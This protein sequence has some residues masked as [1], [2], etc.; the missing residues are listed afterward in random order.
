MDMLIQC[1]LLLLGFVMLVKGADWFV[2]GAAGVADKLG[3]SQLVIG[4][5]I[6]AMGTSAPEAAV[7]ITAALKGN[8]DITI[9]NVVGSNILN[10][11]IILGIVSVIIGTPVAKS[12]IKIDLPFMLG[13]TLL[14]LVLGYFGENISR[15]EG[16]ILLLFF[17][18]YLFYLFKNAK[19]TDSPEENTK[20]EE[21]PVWKLILIALIGLVFIVLGSDFTVDAA[22]KIATELGMGTRF[23]G[24][25]IVALGTSLPELFTSVAAALKGKSDIAIGNIVGSN[26]FNILLIVGLSSVITPIYFAPNFLIDSAVAIAAGVILWIA[27]FK[28]KMLTRPAGIVMLLAYAGYFAYLLMG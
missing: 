28:K 5:T 26:I 22:T 23:I 8:A 27:T 7:S 4:L 6:V 15:L 10:V 16:L 11:L 13:I 18:G 9:G 19:N 12:I 24:L 17:A 25:T 1:L 2:D 14:L 21:K 20:E 3:V